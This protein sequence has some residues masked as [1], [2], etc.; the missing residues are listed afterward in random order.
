MFGRFKA[1]TSWA[2]PLAALALA[3]LASAALADSVTTAGPYWNGLV[4]YT[5]C[6]G[7][8]GIFVIRADGSGRHL[9]YR[10]VHD[11]APLT[12]A[13]SP[14]GK[15]LAFIPGAPRGGVWLVSASG[16]GL[17]RV[18]GG[19]GDS[20]FP[21]WSPTGST[22]VY[23]DLDR[24]RSGRHDLYRVRNDGVAPTRLTSSSADETHPAW[25]PNGNEIVYERGPDLWR[26]SADGR[27][28]RLLIRNAGAPSWSPGGTRIAFIRA[29]DVWTT[30][31]DGSGAVRVADLAAAQIAVA[32]SPDSR[33]LLTAP[34]DRGDLMLI[35][36]NG[37]ETK[38]L[39]RQPDAFHAWPSWQRIPTTGAPQ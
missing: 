3:A 4:A 6:C 30:R 35:R 34:I 21:S 18:T 23:A 38:V 26:M 31:R 37:S 5:Q 17:H 39:T 24:T 27:N 32:W 36:A 12:P 14:N 29:G 9:V 28:Q 7:P 22:L 25:A 19:R 8:A 16:T 15:R 33:W 10:A 11:D 13:W 20:L 1:G 2:I